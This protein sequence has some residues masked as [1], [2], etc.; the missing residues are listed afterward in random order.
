MKKRLAALLTAALLL[1]LSACGPAADPI[2]TA[3]PGTLVSGPD[4]SEN[5]S[6]NA[7]E[8]P[9]E[10]PSSH[11]PDSAEE[12]N[13][14]S[15]SEMTIRITSGENSATFQL[16]DT[17]A[18]EELYDQLPLSLELSNFRDAQWMFYPPEK[19]NVTAAEAYHD[20]KKGEL[21]Y[22]APWGDAFMLYEDFYAGDEM[23][24]LGICLFGM[25]EIAGMSGAAHIGK[26]DATASSSEGVDTMQEN[27]LYLQIGENT[28][29]ATLADNSSAQALKALLANGPVTIEMHDYGNMEKVGSLGTG[30]PTNNEHITT[31]AGDLILYQGS[32]FV[33]YYA[34]NAW[35]FTRLGKIND[36]TQDQLKQALGSGDVKVTLLLTETDKSK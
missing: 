4:R 30:L 3:S 20:G 10:E 14:L 8:P 7:P 22:Y 23:H 15:L 33:I 35:N 5:G 18:A 29:T 11:E 21:G 2:N 6:G 34:P 16:Y 24:R 26:A 9:K 27:L 1:S 36:M 19:L 31:E 17:P 28:L 32:E 13:G 25:D 12:V